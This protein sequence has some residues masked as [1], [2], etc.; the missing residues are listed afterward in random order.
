MAEFFTESRDAKVVFEE[1]RRILAGIFE[2]TDK[3]KS[4]ELLKISLA[5]YTELYRYTK[6][7][8]KHNRNGF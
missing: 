6:N 5:R 7:Y 8:F 1:A 3:S 2:D 4:D